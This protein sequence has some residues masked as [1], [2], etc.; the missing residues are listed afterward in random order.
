MP[1]TTKLREHPHTLTVNSR[2]SATNAFSRKRFA[3]GHQWQS[4]FVL[5]DKKTSI[6]RGN[7]CAILNNS[8]HLQ[9]VGSGQ[10][11]LVGEQAGQCVSLPRS[12][13]LFV[14]EVVQ[15][16]G[17]QWEGKRMGVLS[18]GART[19]QGFS[20]VHPTFTPLNGPHRATPQVP[21]SAYCGPCWHTRNFYLLV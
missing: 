7:P 6:P 11:S 9:S 2:R 14:S 5:K 17:K 10:F 13:L 20:N 12:P 3:V 1:L 19:V 8:W 18:Q 16:Q 15:Y 21:I 4:W